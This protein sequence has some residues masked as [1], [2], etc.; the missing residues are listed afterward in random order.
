MFFLFGLC[1][2][3]RQADNLIHGQSGMWEFAPLDRFGISGG[4]IPVTNETPFFFS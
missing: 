4:I 2:V 3:G 1:S